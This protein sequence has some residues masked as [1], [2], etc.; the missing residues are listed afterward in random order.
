MESR[1]YFLFF[2]FAL[3]VSLFSFE[4]ILTGLAK[5]TLGNVGIKKKMKRNNEKHERKSK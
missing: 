4:P 3:T 2:Y 1:G 5:G